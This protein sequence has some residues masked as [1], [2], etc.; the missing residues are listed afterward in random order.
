M[1]DS[2]GVNN[3]FGMPGILGGIFSAIAISAYAQTPLTD[4]NQKS[5]L[6]FYNKVNTDL[7]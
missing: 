1:Y 4:L 7:N 3:I 5:Y 6:T 2:L